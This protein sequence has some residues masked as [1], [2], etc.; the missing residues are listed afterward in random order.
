MEIF[1]REDIGV[2][3]FRKNFQK[4]DLTK[5]PVKNSLYLSYFFFGDSISDVKMF[6]GSVV[7]KFSVGL[8]LPGRCS[9][10]GRNFHGRKFI[11]GGI[12][13]KNFYRVE[14]QA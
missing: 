9:R 2:Q 4:R 7:G 3:L 6:R 5:I 10:G 8:E 11:L 14:F 1:L 13:W 12:S